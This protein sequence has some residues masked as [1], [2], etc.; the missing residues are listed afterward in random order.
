MHELD[1]TEKAGLDAKALEA[2]HE[3]YDAAPHREHREALYD[4]ITAYLSA[5]PHAGVSEET[6]AC[7]DLENAILACESGQTVFD[8][9][10]NYRAVRRTIQNARAALSSQHAETVPVKIDGPYHDVFAALGVERPAY[11]EPVAYRWRGPKG[12]WIY[13]E[14]KPKGWPSEPVYLIAGIPLVPTTSPAKGGA[15]GPVPAHECEFSIGQP[16]RLA[17][18]YP[19]M[20]PDTVFYIT[21]ISWEH[22]MAPFHG[23]NIEV[24][25]KEDIQKGYG[26]TDGY[27]PDDLQPLR[28]SAP[29]GRQAAP[30]ASDQR[31]P[32]HDQ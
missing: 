26:Q 15:D 10:A 19:E 2:A 25:T 23:W 14:E 7:L 11:A 1:K 32:Q 4:A 18:P 24:A 5:L 13:G 20:D 3:A 22:R 6:A 29:V 28:S 16:V 9:V 30:S 31:G 21:G 12:G 17:H 27:R 8:V